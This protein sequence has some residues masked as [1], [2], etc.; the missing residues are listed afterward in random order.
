MCAILGIH[1]PVVRQSL[2]H[3]QIARICIQPIKSGVTLE[4]AASF[5]FYQDEAGVVEEAVLKG[6]WGIGEIMKDKSGT[7]ELHCTKELCVLQSYLPGDFFLSSGS[8]VTASGIVIL[9]ESNGSK[10]RGSLICCSEIELTLDV[11]TNP[12]PAMMDAFS[13]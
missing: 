13:S 8:T 7:T 6:Q 9:K 10:L 4:G 3:G 12:L 1:R 5:S 2:S 11:K